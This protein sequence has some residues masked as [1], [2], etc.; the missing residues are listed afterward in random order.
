MNDIMGTNWSPFLAC[1]AKIRGLETLRVCILRVC[2]FLSIGLSC[3]ANFSVFWFSFG[4]VFSKH[5]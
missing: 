5:A 3:L 4:N 1:V 2:A